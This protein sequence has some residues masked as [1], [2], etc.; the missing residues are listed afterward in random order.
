MKRPFFA[1]LFVVALVLGSG[2]EDYTITVSDA[3][4]DITAAELDAITNAQSTVTRV[5]KAGAKKLN[6]RVPMPDYK[7]SWRVNAGQ[8]HVYAATNGVGSA[9]DGTDEVYIYSTSHPLV[10]HDA[11]IDKKVTVYGTWSANTDGLLCYGVNRITKAVSVSSGWL[12]VTLFNGATLY[13]DGGVTVPGANRMIFAS[14]GNTHMYLREKPSAINYIS[15]NLAQIHI[16][17]GGNSIGTIQP[18]NSGHVYIEHAEA[19]SGRMPDVYYSQNSG[20]SSTLS[21][22]V[23]RHSFSNLTANAAITSGAI[24]TGVT[25]TG[26]SFTQTTPF[27]NTIVQFTGA[28][29]FTK[30]GPAL[31]AINRTIDTSG[32]L[33]VEEGRLELMSN[34]T[35]RNSSH[36]TVGGTG[37]LAVSRSGVF[38]EGIRLDLNGAAR[39][40]LEL[41][42][43]VT[44][45]VGELYINGVRQSSG[46][47]GGPE[48]GA[49]HS[50]TGRFV[51]KGIVC[52]SSAEPVAPETRAVTWDAGGGV[53][54]SFATAANW[55]G[56][57]TDLDWTSGGVLPTFATAGTEATVAGQPAVKGIVFDPPD[58]DGATSNVFQVLSA[59]A[60]SRLDLGSQGIQA[61]VPS[62][63]LKGWYTIDAPLNL[64]ASQTWY[65]PAT[66]VGELDVTAPV[67]ATDFWK[68]TKD[69]TG[70]LNLRGDNSSFAG[71]V[72]ILNGTVNVYATNAF[73]ASDWP[74]TVYE[75][76]SSKGVNGSL[77]IRSAGNFD[78]PIMLM[79]NA[80]Q[81]KLIWEPVQAAANLYHTRP[82]TVV[83]N[84]GNSSQFYLRL[85]GGTLYSEGGVD[86]TKSDYFGVTQGSVSTWVIRNK[87]MK[88]GSFMLYWITMRFEATG[89]DL[90][91][92]LM[93]ASTSAKLEFG[94]D[95]AFNSTNL[96]VTVDTAAAQWQSNGYIDLRGHSQ[97]IGSLAVNGF[98]TIKS[99][100]APATLYFT[101]QSS[102]VV[103]NGT[104]TRSNPITGGLSLSKAGWQTYCI[105]RTVTSTGGV[106]VTEGRFA[107]GSNAKW[108]GASRIRAAGT[109]VLEINASDTFGRPETY[110][111]GE[112]KIDLAEGVTQHVG[113][114]WL[115]GE[116]VKRCGTY[117]SSASGA[118]FKDDTRFSGTGVLIVHSKFVGSC[119]SFK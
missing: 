97:R 83:G 24:L 41:A 48:S 23:G 44:L 94:C 102:S 96:D 103:T 114:L 14:S 6:L 87:P 31:M 72:D 60:S 35:W 86:F 70:K 4:R 118:K 17:C 26:A 1:F 42:E 62:N 3:D 28:F 7:G 2:A 113:N 15:C 33:A 40:E 11:V 82:L 30:K 105:D 64:T 9:G 13:L 50:D 5:I 112:G 88:G 37:V 110:I 93:C 25:G 61:E 106:E 100:I 111:D 52:V 76:N 95:W 43:D 104:A 63:G 66:T 39:G 55:A 79:T 75:E 84:G 119:I 36:V 74:V 56:D 29:D 59:D 115:D 54:T 90:K 22:N 8:L 67:S 57:P 69:G 65:V 34:C 73:G 80:K 46:F 32:A 91:R 92:L 20:K 78:R 12:P 51:G 58:L 27:T 85:N 47:Y 53:D 16:Q 81:G 77:V 18:Y 98:G 21:L 45:V 109:G 68:L 117:G 38:A 89:N 108:T 99:T 10:L 49:E 101:Q 71:P 116:P 107:F 19:L